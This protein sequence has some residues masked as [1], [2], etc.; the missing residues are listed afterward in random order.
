MVHGCLSSCVC[1][2]REPSHGSAANLSLNLVDEIRT[3]SRRLSKCATQSR[4]YAPSLVL[5][6][7]AVAAFVYASDC[8]AQ[9]GTT[10]P[11]F[12]DVA[13]ATKPITNPVIGFF[14]LVA[15]LWHY[16]MSNASAAILVSASLASLFAFLSIRYQRA[17]TRLRETFATIND[18]NWDKDVIKA[19]T[20]F[21]NV[22]KELGD[23]K[24]DIAK[25]IGAN[26]D[27]EVTEK[28]IFLQTIMND[29]ENLALGVR[30]NIVDEDYLYRWMRST[31]IEDWNSLSP[32][33]AAYRYARRN[34]NVYV[35]FEGLAS[36]WGNGK[37]YRTGRKLKRSFRRLS[38]N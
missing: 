36:S 37:S 27:P 8:L 13:K 7:L 16:L 19:R 25:Y 21:S 24:P 20:V 28:V 18:D 12:E 32:L 35:E 30:H 14:H 5:H 15:L 3:L 34:P 1:V 29:Y 33:V 31:I 17:T 2:R 4:S 10:P 23:N 22:K 11:T 38:V 9:G 26:V 6:V